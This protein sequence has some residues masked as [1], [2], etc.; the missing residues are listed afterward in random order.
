MTEKTWAGHPRGLATLFM[1]EF[2][3][4]FT[5]YGMRALL[6]LFLTAAATADNPGFGIARETAGAIYGL[7]TG[8]VYLFSL[9]GGWIADRLIGQRKAVFWGGVLI[10][11][12]NFTLAIPA[13][14]AVFY[15]G[16]AII[17][18]GVG[19]LKP[20]ISAIVGEL[21]R[22]QPGA[23]R[24]A[25]FSIFYMG[26]NLGAFIAPLVAGTI[27]EGWSWR[28]G[29]FCAGLFMGLG[30]LQYK[31]TEHYLGDAGLEPHA[32]TAAE[33]ARNWKLLALSAALLIVL[34]GLL[35][36]GVIPLGI[37]ELAQIVGSGM[38]ALAFVFFGYVLFFADLTREERGRVAV[39]AIFFLCAALFWA[40]FEQAATTFNLFAQDYTDRSALGGFFPDGVHPA[41]WYQSANPLF[42]ILLSP[43]FAWLWVTLG[44]R[45][46]DPSAPAK[47]GLGLVQLGLG[48]VVLMWAAELAIESGGKVAPTWLLLTYLLHTTGELCLSPVGLSN[49]T[50]L[51]PPR[52]VGQMMGT[53]FLGAAV[54]NLAAGLIGG[55]V[56]AGSI[57]AMPGQFLNMALIGGTAG[58]VLLLFSGVIKRMMGTAAQ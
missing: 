6:I 1:T 25:G 16:L 43:F 49:V 18:V 42:I 47:F 56:G 7:Y 29:F 26:I 38:V 21:Y 3:E 45:N 4:R 12:G 51:S 5:Y 31:L 32:A 8:A 36:A 14:P 11:I 15:L 17:V 24:D 40:G 48:F 50:K 52:Y 55:H 35:Y 22:D 34:V 46:L 54:G 19:L 44:R 53:W 27:G 13:P 39:I 20:N 30:L 10:M 37:T 23:R 57:E 33:R 28:G 9:P 41:S 2:F 58:I